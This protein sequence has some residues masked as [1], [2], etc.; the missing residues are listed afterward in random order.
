MWLNVMIINKDISTQ[1]TICLKKNY[2]IKSYLDK[3]KSCEFIKVYTITYLEMYNSN[4]F[5]S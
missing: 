2:P 4:V 1:Y 3:K 5:E